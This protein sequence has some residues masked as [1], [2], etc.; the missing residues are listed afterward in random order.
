MKD[1]IFPWTGKR[2]WTCWAFV[3]TRS[4]HTGSVSTTKHDVTHTAS[5]DVWRVR[6]RMWR[7]TLV[8][9]VPVDADTLRLDRLTTLERDEGASRNALARDDVQRL[10]GCKHCRVVTI[11][12]CAGQAE[13]ELRH[14]AGCDVNDWRRDKRVSSLLRFRVEVA[15]GVFK[16]SWR[17]WECHRVFSE[18]RIERFERHIADNMAI[19]PWMLHTRRCSH[20]NG[21]ARTSK[22]GRRAGELMRSRETV[23][24]EVL[25]T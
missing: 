3:E 1:V 12:P 24:Q 17:C 21:V 20:R 4:P 16:Q 11:Q 23:G 15:Q 9:W 19:P 10:M 6:P 22:A 5:A 7:N 14:E 13:T 8:V 18:T 2:V 25:F